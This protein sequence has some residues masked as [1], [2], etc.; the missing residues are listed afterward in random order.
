MNK[1]ENESI[2]KNIL[3]LFQFIWHNAK[4]TVIFFFF[5]SVISGM[6][7]MLLLRLNLNI[8]DSLSIGRKKFSDYSIFLIA[9]VLIYVINII[10]DSLQ[11]VFDSIFAENLSMQIQK[12]IMNKIKEIEVANYDNMAF[13]ELLSKIH[14]F[15]GNGASDLIYTVFDILK[16]LI[17]FV[18]QSAF[19]ISLPINEIKFLII[20]FCV[21]AALPKQFFINK[22]SLERYKHRNKVNILNRRAQ[23]FRNSF[24]RNSMLDEMKIFQAT[25]HFKENFHTYNDEFFNRSKKLEYKLHF[26]NRL[27]SMGTFTLN[28]IPYLYFLY[29]A[30]SNAITLGVFTVTTNAIMDINNAAISIFLGFVDLKDH[31]RNA[32]YLMEFLSIPKTSIGKEKDG[33]K[34][35]NTNGKHSIEFRNVTFRYHDG[36]KPILNNI[37]FKINAGETVAFVGKNGEGKSTIIKCLMGLYKPDSGTI[38]ID[39]IP[40]SEYDISNLYQCFG[41]IFQDYCKYSLPL[42][43]FIMLGNLSEPFDKE[44]ALEEI[45]KCNFN[46]ILAKMPQGFDT[47]LTKRFTGD[48]VELS[49]GQ[50]QKLSLVKALYNKSEIMIFD[51]PSASLDIE[52]ET[53]LFKNM[54]Q[55]KGEKTSI[56]ISHNLSSVKICDT[57]F[58]LQDGSI[59]AEGSHEILY[60]SNKIY[61]K[62]Y[63]AQANRFF[64]TVESR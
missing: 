57:I 49:I 20:P 52:T 7:P 33:I 30:W 42:W 8:I 48:A 55:C 61:Q 3:Y 27:A 14:I 22:Q 46:D 47:L 31:G 25:D 63:H 43:E 37:S 4:V 2:Y 5:V 34:I 13:N 21:L 58:L 12:K 19:F 10:L 6:I 11:Y 40:I 38:L 1:R 64:N 54:L 15:S 36:V 60:Q 26:L 35:A 56:F 23:Y 45:Q 39:D 51:E 9:I 41:V 59:L 50:W 16:N 29:L 18:S 24:F 28:R 32:S 17:I 62:M 44:R 53:Q